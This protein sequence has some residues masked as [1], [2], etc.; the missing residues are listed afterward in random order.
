MKQPK[1]KDS[2]D[3]EMGMDR[4]DSCKYF[5]QYYVKASTGQYI[6]ALVGECIL[7]PSENKGIRESYSDACAIYTPI[8]TGAIRMKS[9]SFVDL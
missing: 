4:C 6:P 9:K 7:F 3:P 8:S 5:I 2:L 1:T